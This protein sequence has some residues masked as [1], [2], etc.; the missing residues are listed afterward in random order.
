LKGTDHTEDQH[1]DEEVIKLERNLEKQGD[2][3]CIHLPQY[4]DQWWGSCK[5]DDEPSVSMKDG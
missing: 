5:Y 1:V 3:E 4:R 2:A